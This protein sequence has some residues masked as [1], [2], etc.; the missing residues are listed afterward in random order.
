MDVRNPN[1]TG[2]GAGGELAP[3]SKGERPAVGVRGLTQ[4]S[5]PAAGGWVPEADQVFAHAAG[6]LVKSYSPE[7]AAQCHLGKV[8][9]GDELTRARETQAD[10]VPK[11]LRK[12]LATLP[13]LDVPEIHDTLKTGRNQG[14]AVRGEGNIIASKFDSLDA[15]SQQHVPAR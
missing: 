13:G 8:D 14:A 5:Q 10:N 7:V 9:S 6:G 2:A 4:G 15:A 1:R 12:E 11:R 3:R